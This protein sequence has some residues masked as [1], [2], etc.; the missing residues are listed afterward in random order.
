[1]DVVNFQLG[2]SSLTWAE[3][4]YQNSCK[5]PDR[6]EQCSEIWARELEHHNDLLAA[7]RRNREVAH[8]ANGATPEEA[9]EMAQAEVE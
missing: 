6:L 4:D 2:E 9:A 7:W 5:N 1:M 3:W 8:Q